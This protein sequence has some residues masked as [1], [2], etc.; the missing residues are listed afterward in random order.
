MS[1]SGSQLMIRGAVSSEPPLAQIVSALSYQ[2]GT[3]DDC[4]S[5]KT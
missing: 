3:I 2:S 5:S 1:Y 4:D